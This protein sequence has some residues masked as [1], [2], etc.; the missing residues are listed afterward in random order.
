MELVEGSAL[1]AISAAE[2]ALRESSPTY[3]LVRPPGHHAGPSWMGGLCYINNAM[4][5]AKYLEQ[6]LGTPVGVIDLDFHFGDGSS[7]VALRNPSIYFASVHA[8]ASAYYPRLSTEVTLPDQYLHPLGA[9]PTAEQY[10]RTVAAAIEWLCAHDVGGM[11]AS[12]GYDI[13]DGDPYGQ[14]S[15]PAAICL[16]L[17]TL[18]R[19]VDIPLC[20]VQEGGY[21]HST[22]GV[23]AANLAAGLLG[24]NE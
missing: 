8:S 16:A 18:F 6:S 24:V 3:A 21:E 23:A 11:V 2:L 19:R 14:W 4:L 17:G 10:V 22:V 13:V 5:A 12:V 15:F 20:F 9:T 7:A 1:V